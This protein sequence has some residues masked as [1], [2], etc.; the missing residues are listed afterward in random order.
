MLT[1]IVIDDFYDVARGMRDED[2]P[3]LWIECGMVEAAVRS[4]GY[5]DNA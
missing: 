2:P 4:V 3:G 1:S 5:L